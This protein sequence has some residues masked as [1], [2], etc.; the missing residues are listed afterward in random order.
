MLIL[1]PSR[2]GSFAEL[3][4]DVRMLSWWGRGAESDDGNVRE[5]KVVSPLPRACRNERGLL[6]RQFTARHCFVEA[7]EV[8]GL[9]WIAVVPLGLDDPHLRPEVRHH[10]IKELSSGDG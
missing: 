3:D 10:R 5:S 1:T 4:H 7:I 9:V 2:H 6:L 8:R